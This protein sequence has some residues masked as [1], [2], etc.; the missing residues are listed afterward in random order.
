MFMFKIQTLKF[1]FWAQKYGKSAAKDV[2]IKMANIDK[3]IIQGGKKE[4]GEFHG[5][6]LDVANELNLLY[7]VVCAIKIHI[8]YNIL[9]S[10]A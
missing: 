9:A 6:F 3:I 1:K 7:P 10:A 5:K 8:W 2:H 4:T